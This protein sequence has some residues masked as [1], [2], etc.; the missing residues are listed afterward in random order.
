M[1]REDFKFNEGAIERDRY[2]QGVWSNGK[3]TLDLDNLNS[4]A[5]MESIE[6][7]AMG[8]TGVNTHHFYVTKSGTGRERIQYEVIDDFY[9]D[10]G[11]ITHTEVVYK[12]LGKNF[13]KIADEGEVD[14]DF[15]EYCECFEK[16]VAADPE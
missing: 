2:Y 14:K 8:G 9:L 16:A 5:E 11:C 7:L 12:T 10:I 13:K 4:K 15:L 1:G 6:D 3:K